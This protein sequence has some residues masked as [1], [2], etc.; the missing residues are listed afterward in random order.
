LF[1]ACQSD[2]DKK[3]SPTL[4]STYQLIS[5]GNISIPINKDT[6]PQTYCLKFFDGEQGEKIYYLDRPNNTII[7]YSL[8]TLRREQGFVFPFEGSNGVGKITGFSVLNDNK[9]ILSSSGK[10]WFYAFDTN[11]QTLSRIDYRDADRLQE[12]VYTPLSS[13]FYSEAYQVN[14]KLY[15]LQQLYGSLGSVRQVAKD[16]KPI[17]IYDLEAKASSLLDFGFP[18]TYFE[19][20]TLLHE[21]SLACDGKK[22]VYSLRCD[23]NLYVLDIKTGDENIAPAKSQFIDEFGNA[24]WST[25][26]EYLNFVSRNSSYESIIYDSFRK[27]YYRLARLPIEDPTTIDADLSSY[28]DRFT[29]LILNEQLEVIGESK[30]DG[31]M[32][33]MY[34]FF[35]GKEGLYISLNNPNN[36]DYNENYLQFEVFTLAA[37]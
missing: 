1:T 26:E 31:K 9:L 18:N 28:P 16:W 32:Y 33:N 36:S 19:E 24:E 27:V 20:K 23:H 3:Q 10:P 4:S 11:D 8:S 21:A 17:M 14:D 35:T 30:M 25:R 15:F 22:L 2:E 7:V 34:N 5:K 37:L 13:R 6:P 12:A 29:I